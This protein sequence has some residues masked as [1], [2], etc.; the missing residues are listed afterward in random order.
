M[1]VFKIAKD[2]EILEKQLREIENK[3]SDPIERLEQKKQLE[4]KIK[5]L[6]QY[7]SKIEKLEQ[8]QQELE[9]L[10]SEFS[11]HNID[12]LN[13]QQLEEQKCNTITPVN[14][15]INFNKQ[16]EDNSD[17]QVNHTNSLEQNLHNTS[18]TPHSNQL[19][20]LGK[21]F[22]IGGIV[23]FFVFLGLIINS[24]RANENE[25]VSNVQEQTSNTISSETI[26]QD[27]SIEKIIESS[28]NVSDQ[29]QEQN[30]S[31]YDFPVDSCGDRDPGGS[32]IW[33][34][35]YVYYTPENLST[36][37]NNYCKDAF[38]KY[39]QQDQSYSIQIASFT[40]ELKATKFAELMQINIGSG[41]VGEPLIYN[42]D[43]IINSISSQNHLTNSNIAIS[44]LNQN[45]KEIDESE[46]I[47]LITRLYD[48]L[49]QKSFT[50]AEFLYN[51]QLADQFNSNFFSQFERVTVQ[52]LRI[53][54]KTK[55]TINFIGQNTYIWL[56]GSTQQESRS[57]KVENLNGKLQVTDSKFLKVTK[58]R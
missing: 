19:K 4:K 21:A 24:N 41:K 2:L 35:V 34:P 10:K 42:F 16:T 26:K 54:A 49:S 11:L 29:L 48:L 25:I 14:S 44:D 33:F 31:N 55:N 38:R 15:E 50:E 17:S 51:T 3:V 43:T 12:L 52:D 6:E 7:K 36:I 30:F 58:F 47:T 9:S 46:S 13:K 37:H 27:S 28:P 22:I 1:S 18:I 32:N 40:N 5:K 45:Y 57:Y 56:D 39:N 20:E 8:E 53:T 23:G